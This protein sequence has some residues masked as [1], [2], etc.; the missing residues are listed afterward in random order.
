MTKKTSAKKG[1]WVFISHSAKDRW[2]AR[3][4]ALLIEERGRLYGVQTFLDE[5]DIEAGES[6][7]DSIRKN[8]ARVRRIPGAP[9]SILYRSSVGVD[10]NGCGLGA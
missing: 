1:H 4:M 10:R 2:I 8:I 9:D 7:P 6:I 5:K 3:Q